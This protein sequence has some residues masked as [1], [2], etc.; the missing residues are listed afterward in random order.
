MV[1]KPIEVGK[2]AGKQVVRAWLLHF[3]FSYPL[4]IFGSAIKDCNKAVS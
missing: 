4:P 2:R 3:S 1:D